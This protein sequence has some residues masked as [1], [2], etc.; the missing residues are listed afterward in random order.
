M[1]FLK[2]FTMEDTFFGKR[3]ELLSSTILP[4]QEAAIKDQIPGAAKSH[5]AANFEAAARFQKTGRKTEEFYGE[6]F[7]DSDV[8]KWLEAAAYSLLK[9]PDAELKQRALELI[10]TIGEAQYPDGYL[11]TFFTLKY[12]ERKFTNFQDAHELYCAGHMMEAAV[13]WHECLEN[14]ELMQIMLR[15]ADCLYEH[16]IVRKNPGYSGHPEIELALLRM[17]KATGEEKCLQLAEHFLNARGQ[18]PMYFLKES[19]ARDWQLGNTSFN[20]DPYYAQNYAPVRK[21][22][23][24]VGHAVRA[25]YL[26]AGMAAYAKL[27][28]GTV[29]SDDAKPAGGTG[30]SDDAKPAGGTGLSYDAK[31]AGGTGLLSDGKAGDA[32]MAEACRALYE[33]ITTKQMYVTGGIGSTYIGEAFT[34][35]YNL[36]NDTVYSET[37]ASVGLIFFARRMLDLEPLGEY[38]DTMERALYNCVLG[39]MQLDGQRFFYVNPL[40]VDPAVSGVIPTHRH[41]LPKR[42]K[43]FGCA[44]C[45]PNVARLL[46]SLAEYAWGRTKDTIYVNLYLAGRLELPDLGVRILAD[47]GGYPYGG[48]LFYRIIPE[49]PGKCFTFAIRVPAWSRNTRVTCDGKNVEIKDGFAYIKGP[50]M[51]ETKVTVILDMEPHKVYANPSA[52]ADNGKVAIQR[53]PLIYCAEQADQE[54]DL[55]SIRA[56]E[57]GGIHVLPFDEKTLGGIVPLELDARAEGEFDGLYSFKKPEERK[58]RLRLIP[59]YAWGNRET[60]R[61]RVWIPE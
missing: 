35:D 7:Q 26:Y 52:A 54:A 1:N 45:P 23:K 48:D 16:F 31:P 47:T 55:F 44:C 28:G 11:D 49:R 27:A 4:Y 33:S 24:A 8:A 37:C 29:F 15:N 30:L 36:P 40:E 19:K 21:Q 46:G 41:V 43:W 56:E 13:A 25:V 2:D 12:P 6:V 3:E 38:A 20:T 58:C 10:H 39:G 42:P 50:F 18:D 57:D 22:R 61:M 51:E 17:Y 59:Y 5:A 14:D 9:T 32:E 53:G 34:T 60:G